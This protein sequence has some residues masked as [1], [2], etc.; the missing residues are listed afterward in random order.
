MIG[1]AH[2]WMLRVGRMIRV[3]RSL[4]QLRHI[5]VILRTLGVTRVDVGAW[6][7]VGLLKVKWSSV[8]MTGWVGAFNATWAL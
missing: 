7:S 1:Y 4:C 6:D 8:S 3:L 2:M 5:D